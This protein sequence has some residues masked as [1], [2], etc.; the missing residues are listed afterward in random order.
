MRADLHIHTTASDGCWAPERVVAEV[1]A[2][3]IGLFA[4]ADHDTIANVPATEAL[5]RE[6]G[7]AFLRGVEVSASLDGRLFHILVYGFA[8]RSSALS[9]LLGENRARMEQYNGGIIHAL[10][11]AGYPIDADDYATYEYD[12][13]RGGWKGLNFSIDRGICTGVRDFFDDL[14]AGL[15]LTMPTFPHPSTV[16]AAARDAGGATILAHPGMSLRHAG[17][18]AETLRPFLDSGIAGLE[19]YSQYHDET[20]TRFCLDWCA[21]HD[22]LVTGGSDCHGGFVGREVGV[23]VVDTANLRLGEL[24]KRIIAPQATN[25]RIILADTANVSG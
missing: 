25:E 14:L 20:T 8:P 12:P 18:T 9:A 24:E 5:A 17:V 13:G 6:S 19:C 23:P 21:R 4:I 22:L 15:P 16:V 7:L 10:I 2:R 3:P 1:A 11:E